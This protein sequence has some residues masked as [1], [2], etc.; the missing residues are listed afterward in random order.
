[1]W[2]EEHELE[3]EETLRLMSPV[4]QEHPVETVIFDSEL[5]PRQ[6]RNLSRALDDRVAICDRTMLILDIFSQRART[7]EGQLQV[8]MASLEYQLPR[9]TRMWTHLERQAGGAGGGA[10]VKGMGEKQIEIDK[11]LLRDRIVFLKKKLDKVSTHRDLYRGRRKEAPVPVVSL[12]GYT[13]AGKS[14]LLNALTFQAGFNATNGKAKTVLAED[15]LFATLDPTTR[16]VSLP[17]GKTALA[18][19]TVGFI[20][21]L[22]TNLVAA[23]RATLEEIKESSL[24]LH[25]VDVSSPLAT[26][27]IKA[28]DAV[29]DEL[30]VRDIPKLV[31]WNKC[32]ALDD[33]NAM[34]DDGFGFWDDDDDD[35]GSSGSGGK[36]VSFPG[37][38]L[39]DDGSGDLVV[40]DDDCE[41]E[42]DSDAED[43]EN[44]EE[45]ET[46]EERRIQSGGF[47][48][49]ENHAS[50]PAWI[51]SAARRRG[52]VATSARTGAGVKALAQEIQRQLVRHSMVPVSVLLPYEEGKLLGEIRRVGVVETEA[53]GD[54]GVLVAA[55]VPPPTARRLRRFGHAE[56]FPRDADTNENASEQVA[57]SAEEEAELAELMLE[58]EALEARTRRAS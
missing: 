57:W 56:A 15:K 43:E 26:A 36:K 11:R 19:D 4:T 44:D 22:P 30:G 55:H 17:D 53:Y 54:D 34:E 1:V 48:K 58:E 28:V 25:V 41:W 50:I 46:N 5:T 38:E 45:T 9:L 51:K 49:D 42:E 16:R 35:D 32:D 6:A 8:E 39:R 13:N 10:Q 2:D 24:L 31:V 3:L 18:T 20:Q 14:S 33:T 37:A 21:R 40:D 52:A 7:A 29:L 23:F 27:Q 12:V 47:G